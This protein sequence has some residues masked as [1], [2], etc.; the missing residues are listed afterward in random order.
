MPASMSSPLFGCEWARDNI[1]DSG[2][3]VY[4]LHNKA[5]A[6]DFFLKHGQSSIAGDIA[7]E[8]VR[9]RWLA[10]HI[11]VPAVEGFVFAQD[12]ARLFD[13]GSTRTDRIPATGGAS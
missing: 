3:A 5:G 4:R 1:G 7:D 12:E 6:P 9:L 2:G 8:M 13:D 11:P 10:R